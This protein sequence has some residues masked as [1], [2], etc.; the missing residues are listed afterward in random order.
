MPEIIRQKGLYKTSFVLCLIAITI[1]SIIPQK[2]GQDLILPSLFSSGADHH[3][4]AYGVAMLLG[5][6]S[7]RR[8]KVPLFFFLLFYGTLLEIVQ[9][10]LPTRS[11]NPFDILANVAGIFIAL[12]VDSFYQKVLKKRVKLSSP[13]E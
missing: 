6:A 13:S 10:P 2:E 8:S 12:W 3:A 7:F 5:L 9:I 11:F 4:L 1:L